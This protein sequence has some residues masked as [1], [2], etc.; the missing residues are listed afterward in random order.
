MK[1]LG[2]ILLVILGIFVVLVVAFNIKRVFSGIDKI[3]Y[4]NYKE[5]K[6]YYLE[7]V[8]YE[9]E[10]EEILKSQPSEIEGMTRYDKLQAGLS[11]YL[12]DTDSDGISDADELAIG[13][14]PT[15]ASTSGDLYPDGYKL[16]HDMDLNTYYEFEQVSVQLNG[17]TVEGISVDI[18]STED[19]N[20]TAE[21]CEQEDKYRGVYRIYKISGFKG[22]VSIDLASVLNENNVSMD[23]IAIYC[24]G[25]WDQGDLEDCNYSV[26]GTII[27]FDTDF[28]KDTKYLYIVNAD[29]YDI[30]SSKTYEGRAIIFGSPISRNWGNGKFNIWYMESGDE[31]LDEMILS[32]MK[33]EVY[34]VTDAGMRGQNPVSAEFDNIEIKKSY[35][36]EFKYKILQYIIPMFECDNSQN[37]KWYQIFYYFSDYSDVATVD[38]EIGKLKPSTIKMN[39]SHMEFDYNRDILPFA[40][41][42]SEISWYGNC[43]GIAALT[44]K[45]YNGDYI[46]SSGE[47]DVKDKGYYVW[48]ISG[49]EENKTLTDEYLFDYK[50]ADFTKD[51][52]TKYKTTKGNTVYLLDKDMSKGEMQFM[53][54]IG[55]YWAECNDCLKDNS[56]Y[57]YM[58]A[59]NR[60][61]SERIDAAKN[62][63]DKN[64]ILIT[65]FVSKEV[66]GHAV[67]IVGY[68]ELANGNTKFFV[69][70]SNFPDETELY[71]LVQP[72]S[73]G[74]FDYLYTTPCY[75]F[76]SLIDGNIFIMSDDNYNELTNIVWSGEENAGIEEVEMREL[77]KKVDVMKHKMNAE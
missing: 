69:Y 60:Y 30:E 9:A 3:K 48:D 50:D 53:Y 56:D 62:H 65:G 11:P 75:E 70:D 39:K 34:I 77:Q 74:T 15:K 23:D 43:A 58:Y 6:D 37:M 24:R 17:I 16:L 25:F 55:C 35:D 10:N 7:E 47:Y 64:K 49:D 63:L 32:R 29:E 57:T 73:D 27:S 72:R 67:N 12:D 66:G 46:P 4:A 8:D 20:G 19:F 40:N 44:A 45:T 21:E 76:S 71:V 54:M 42:G 2:K 1:K 41:F 52:T 38:E 5:G 61:S 28:G 59:N 22:A 13:S 18:A 68:E 33:E 31:V 51:H 36:I 26:D 14:D